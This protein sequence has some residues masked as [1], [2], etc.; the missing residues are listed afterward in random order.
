MPHS[1]CSVLHGVTPNQNQMFANQNISFFQGELHDLKY[2]MLSEDLLNIMVVY[3]Y[4]SIAV[5]T[6]SLH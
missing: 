4:L 1:D 2:Q 5:K 3:I 6:K